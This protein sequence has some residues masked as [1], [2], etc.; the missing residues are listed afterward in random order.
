[1]ET[2]NRREINDL[3]LPDTFPTRMMIIMR[4]AAQAY[5]VLPIYLACEQAHAGTQACTA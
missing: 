1:M 4:P 5:L 3:N 2:K